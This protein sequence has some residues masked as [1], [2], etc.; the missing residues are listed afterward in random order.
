[1]LCGENYK[2]NQ[3]TKI[4]GGEMNIT[5]K[6]KKQAFS[7]SIPE[8]DSIMIRDYMFELE[9]YHN[10]LCTSHGEQKEEYRKD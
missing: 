5:E 2:K 1:M 6:P 8:D 10:A 4:G 3:E 9:S 7:V